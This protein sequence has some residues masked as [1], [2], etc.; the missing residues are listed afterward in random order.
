ML[1]SHVCCDTFNLWISHLA[2]PQQRRHLCT[3]SA[4]MLTDHHTGT[5]VAGLSF[6]AWVSCESRRPPC[7]MFFWGVNVEPCARVSSSV[8]KWPNVTRV[9]RTRARGSVNVYCS[10]CTGSG[11]RSQRH[12]S[13][14]L[15]LSYD[16]M[17]RGI[18]WKKKKQHSS[19][20]KPKLYRIPD[21]NPPSRGEKNTDDAKNAHQF[22]YDRLRH[23]HSLHGAPI[24]SGGCGGKKKTKNPQNY[25]VCE[26]CQRGQE[27]WRRHEG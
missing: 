19:W 10:G 8:T 24:A 6:R 3:W 1:H 22:L 12:F 25:V 23:I 7:E 11:Y 2:K 14:G 5:S 20:E 18:Q 15:F 13:H 9:L 21:T 26:L 17:V 16:N 4:I 27:Y